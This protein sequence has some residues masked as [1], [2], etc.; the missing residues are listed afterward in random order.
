MI[1]NIAQGV[2][3]GFINYF[4]KYTYIGT[5]KAWVDAVAAEA[6]DRKNLYSINSSPTDIVGPRNQSNT[7]NNI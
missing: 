1:F 3:Q 5:N 7:I 2:S 6:L 4:D